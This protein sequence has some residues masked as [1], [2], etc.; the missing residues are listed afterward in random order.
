MGFVVIIKWNNLQWTRGVLW[1][2]II[3]SSYACYIHEREQRET[4]IKHSVWNGYSFIVL[5]L[6][7]I[8]CLPS[9]PPSLLLL[10]LFLEFQSGFV[11][12]KKKGLC[13]SLCDFVTTY[14]TVNY[15]NAIDLSFPW[16]VLFKNISFGKMEH[17]FPFCYNSSFQPHPL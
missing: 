6:L 11:K 14:V 7:S 8:G 1:T 12:K 15:S 16:Y 4:E 3:C 17:K 5:F 9:F 2:T 10:L 13:T